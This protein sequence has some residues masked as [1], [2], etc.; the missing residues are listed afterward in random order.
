MAGLTGL[1]FALTSTVAPAQDTA[2]MIATAAIATQAREIAYFATVGARTISMWWATKQPL[3]MAIVAAVT[4]FNVVASI[5]F[6]E[7]I[8]ADA[9]QPLS[10]TNP[11]LR[12]PIV[13]H[14]VNNPP[15]KNPDPTKW[16]NAPATGGAPMPKGEYSSTAPTFTVYATNVS[17]T[18]VCPSTPAP[19]A[20]CVIYSTD[21]AG[22]VRYQNH[23]YQVP[24]STV[25]SMPQ[26]DADGLGSVYTTTTNAAAGYT[27]VLYRKAW[28]GVTCGTGGLYV[29]DNAR[30]K[31]VLIG[32]AAN[33]PKPEG[34]ICEVF[35]NAAWTIYEDT[36]NPEC[37]K[38]TAPTVSTPGAASDPVMKIKICYTGA[39]GNPNC[40]YGGPVTAA[41]A[42]V[43]YEALEPADQPTASNPGEV[44]EQDDGV[45]KTR[46]YLGP[47]NT[48]KGGR[49]VAGTTNKPSS[50]DAT[51]GGSG[52]GT[53][54]GGTGTG[55]GTGGGTTINNTG[56][57]GA[58][59]FPVCSTTTDD[60][61]FKD[62]RTD[63]ATEGL[64]ARIARNDQDQVTK[65]N[66]VKGDDMHG[67]TF[68]TPIENILPDTSQCQVMHINLGPNRTWNLDL[69][70]GLAR[71]RQLAGYALYILT[72]FGIFEIVTR[73]RGTGS[74]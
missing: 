70:T 34:T 49:V 21:A 32:S 19:N 6:G 55:G 24:S 39:N 66:G 35:H 30:S 40:T 17:I 36:Q 42:G 47:V 53:G 65:L 4:V 10:P 37:K 2:T 41:P 38:T 54:T 50:G 33:V 1:S 28:S 61:G 57:C 63:S 31:C 60:S 62:M 74:A 29:W 8:T 43:G 59:G 45:T 51:Q 14:L 46:T 26:T 15:L 7:K 56:V 16:D 20:D 12:G 73:Q 11:G 22:T 3:G 18:N 5:E 52:T 9:S 71:W 67:I 58:P 69:C 48:T 44:W 68:G 13:V 72:A 25:A 64:G 23:V 27:K